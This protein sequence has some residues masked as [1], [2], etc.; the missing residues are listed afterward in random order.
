M[1]EKFLPIGT[2][3]MLKGGTKRL[4]ITGFCMFDKKQSNKVFDYCGCLYPEG[5][6]S[7][8]QIALF[9]HSQIKEIYHIGLEDDEEKEFKEQL[10]KL[11]ANNEEE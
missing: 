7:S 10:N 2:V 11:V 1:R 9:D 8:D 3:V 4:M 5:V 6:V